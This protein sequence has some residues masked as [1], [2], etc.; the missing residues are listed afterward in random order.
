MK[1]F[2]SESKLAR[3]YVHQR[4]RYMIVREVMNKRNISREDANALVPSYPEMDNYYMS[5]NQCIMW[6]NKWFFK[7][8]HGNDVILDGEAFSF[9][10]DA[11]NWLIQLDER[12]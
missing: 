9:N 10:Q 8:G 11:I 7:Q 12:R 4:D 2:F 6:S 1:M 5:D 3:K